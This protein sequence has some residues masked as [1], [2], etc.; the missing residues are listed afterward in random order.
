MNCLFSL[1]K[2]TH[3]LKKKKKKNSGCFCLL[4]YTWFDIQSCFASCILYYMPVFCMQNSKSLKCFYW[5]LVLLYGE[6]SF[7]SG[8]WCCSLWPKSRS[9]VTEIQKQ[10]RGPLLFVGTAST[11]NDNLHLKQEVDPDWMEIPWMLTLICATDDTDWTA[12]VMWN[13]S[14][15]CVGFCS[16]FTPQMCLVNIVQFIT[17]I[18]HW[19]TWIELNSNWFELNRRLVVTPIIGNEWFGESLL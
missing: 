12:P 10:H 4:L 14:H 11:D 3:Q 2:W 17:H 8:E 16:E 9:K 6:R 18:Y 5:R 7:N 13:K 15:S 1:Y 19:S